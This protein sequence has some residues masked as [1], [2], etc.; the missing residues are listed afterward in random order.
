MR[1]LIVD[2]RPEM[3]MLLRTFIESEKHTVLEATNGQEAV[4]AAQRWTPDLILM[5]LCM[6]VMDGYEATRQI[7][8]T[9][10]GVSIPIVAISAD[11]NGGAS[12]KALDAGCD[13]CVDKPMSSAQLHTLFDILAQ[14]AHI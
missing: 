10:S 1:I 9:Q 11:Y 5:D 4:E 13:M 2:D 8:K 7:R 14:A 6:P 12:K 3:R